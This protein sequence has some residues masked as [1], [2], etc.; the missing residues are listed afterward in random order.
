MID[1]TL[2]EIINTSYTKNGFYNKLVILREFF[3]YLFFSEHEQVETHVL[4]EK[5]L[6]E[7]DVA[8]DVR[9]S[10]TK[11]SPDFFSSFTSENLSDIFHKLEEYLKEVPLIVLYVPILLPREE[12]KGLGEWMR[13]NVAKNIFMELKVDPGAVG[14]CSFVWNSVYNDFSH[15]YFFEKKRP[16]IITMLRNYGD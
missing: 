1:D 11:L 2:R 6:A 16:E 5:F 4:F 10:L 8:E 13:V 14:G 3:E 9:D 15:R 7:R 12:I